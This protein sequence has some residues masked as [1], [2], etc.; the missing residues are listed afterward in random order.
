M[1][2]ETTR[3]TPGPWHTT[4]KD[5]G[6]EWWFG[7]RGE[8]QCIVED[9][10]G[11]MI[12]VYGGHDEANARLIAAAPDLLAALV[13]AEPLLV[14]L[15]ERVKRAPGG[16]ETYTLGVLADI[17]AAVARAKGEQP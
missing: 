13:E 12:A 17:R 8:G 16:D 9:A 3:H 4:H 7:G 10:S 15:I 5:Y 14:A 11:E 1:T 2:T 6:D